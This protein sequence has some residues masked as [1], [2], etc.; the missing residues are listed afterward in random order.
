MFHGITDCFALVELEEEVPICS[1]ALFE[2]A[3][4][5]PRAVFFQ[6]DRIDRHVPK[7][8]GGK[9]GGLD[10][11]GHRGEFAGKQERIQSRSH[12]ESGGGGDCALR[13]VRAVGVGPLAT[14]G[15]GDRSGICLGTSGLVLGVEVVQVLG[16]GVAH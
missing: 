3:S 1:G 9:V 5:E 6:I 8:E 15:G 7:E 4:H 2:D 12:E 10:G 11:I 16:H 13:G 14:N